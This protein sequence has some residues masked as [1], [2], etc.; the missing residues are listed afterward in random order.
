MQ[1]KRDISQLSISYMQILEEND[2]ESDENSEQINQM[3]N[4][5]IKYSTNC[6]ILSDRTSFKPKFSKISYTN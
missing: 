3:S 1:M 6:N 5:N 4:R 2:E